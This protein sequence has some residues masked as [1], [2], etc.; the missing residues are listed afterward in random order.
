MVV[1]LDL[2]L[3]LFLLLILLRF[4]FQLLVIHMVGPGGFGGYGKQK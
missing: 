3:E 4:H 2:V 1:V